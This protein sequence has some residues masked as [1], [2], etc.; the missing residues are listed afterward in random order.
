M[1]TS[2]NV[3]EAMTVA[4]GGR[5]DYIDLLKGFTIIW[6]LWMHMDMPELIYP[7]VQMP[8]FFFIS[9]T[10][11]H[12][13][14]P[15]LWQQVKG[16]ARRLLAPALCFSMFAFC[17]QAAS[18][19]LVGGGICDIINGCLS[20]S[21]VW[22]LIALFYFRTMAFP[23]VRRRKMLLLLIALLIYAPGFYLYAHHCDWIVPFVPLSHM[24]V[25][26]IWFALGVLW[27][28]D[29][30]RWLATAARR[31]VGIWVLLSILYVLLVHC[32]DWDAVLHVHLPWLL[33][34]FPYTVGVIFVMLL[35]AYHV[36]KVGWLRPIV[37]V[38]TY[39][40]K[41]SIVFYLTHWPL[42]MYFF[43]PL[44][45]NIYLSFLCIVLLEFPLIYVFTHYL[46][47]C[48]GK[49]YQRKL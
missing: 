45:W 21:I 47:W 14:A 13:K 18:G 3:A 12:A 1:E 41:N 6:V 23:C 42:W 22:F 36:E 17:Y 30:L 26:M 38:L 40:G 46:P 43:K 28:K 2:V 27:G 49:T 4:Q 8:V 29:V 34:G 48:I 37:K 33:Q 11:Y 19:K 15:G 10:F 20:A 5:Y 24:G 16:D 31:K 35:V 7:S 9:G 32:V 44:G 25:F 39:V